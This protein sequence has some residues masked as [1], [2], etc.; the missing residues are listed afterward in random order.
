MPLACAGALVGMWAAVVPE[1]LGWVDVAGDLVGPHGVTGWE[2]VV[3]L[4]DPLSW[5]LTLTPWA[6]AGAGGAAIGA[7]RRH[8]PSDLDVGRVRTL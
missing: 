7:V 6:M 2:G 1:M 3:G 8:W 5:I 4:L